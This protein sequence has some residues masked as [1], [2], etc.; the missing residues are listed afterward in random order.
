MKITKSIAAALV[1][2][3]ATGFSSNYVG[4]ASEN[5]KVKTSNQESTLI[6]LNTS[7]EEIKHLPGGNDSELPYI[8]SPRYTLLLNEQPNISWNPVA[9]ATL[10]LVRIEGPGVEWLAETSETQIVYSGEQP[11]EAGVAY[12]VTVE[13]DTGTSSID[14]AGAK[15]GF[16]VV[17]T[18]KAQSI[19][20]Q[21]EEIAKSSL[22]AE[23]KAI[24]TAQ[25]Y[26][27]YM[28]KAEA[29]ATLETLVNQ[30]NQTGAVYKMLGDLYA[31]T[32]LNLLAEASYNQAIE[33][34]SVKQEQMVLT[35]AQAGLAGVNLMLGNEEEAQEMQKLAQ[36]GYQEMGE[37][38]KAKQLEERLTMLQT[39]VAEDNVLIG[40]R[41]GPTQKEE[42]DIIAPDMFDGTSDSSDEPSIESPEYEGFGS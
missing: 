28:F 39:G 35:E 5:T 21:A 12:K 22:S 13:A 27:E 9:G 16:R 3:L 42:A 8:I 25:L 18:E 33:L 38:E 23:E 15:L 11:L 20:Q 30:G 19:Q 24:A 26:S 29:I 37:Q 10:Y 2:T 4:L 31:E 36:A 34:A 6:S 17:E 40:M 1:L 7:S 32:G 14:D 41:G